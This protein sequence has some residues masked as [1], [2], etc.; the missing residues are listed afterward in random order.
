MTNVTL[1]VDD[2]IYKRMKQY[3]EIMWSEFVRKTI[4]RR[5]D[6]LDK[7]DEEKKESLLTM[8]VSE[9]VLA[10]DWDSEEDQHWNDV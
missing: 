1:S 3:S 10:E 8:L 4:E 6:E 5:L 9:S 7:L 2:K